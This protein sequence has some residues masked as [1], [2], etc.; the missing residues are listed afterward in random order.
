M[1]PPPER[2]QTVTSQAIIAISEF[3]SRYP[4]SEQ[5]PEFKNMLDELSE[6]LMEKS[7]MN[8][9]TY[10][11]IGRY[12]SAIVAFKNSMKQHPTSPYT[13]EMMYYTTVSAFRLAENS[14]ESKQLD[15]YMSTLDAYY[16]FVMEYP[17]SKYKKEVDQM[18]D[19]A[20]RF[21]EKNKKEE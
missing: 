1:S 17:E 21:I 7:Y 15:R 14:V 11:K 5:A 3:L 19:V 20:K 18:A 16:T 10:Y 6:R 12:K 9:Y 2:D 13:E 8:A 4:N